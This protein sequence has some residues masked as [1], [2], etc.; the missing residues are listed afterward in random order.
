MTDVIGIP[1]ELAVPA[2]SER[3][4]AWFIIHTYSGYEAK[5]MES[6]R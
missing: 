1:Q 3:K 5:V 4:L 2:A 6:L